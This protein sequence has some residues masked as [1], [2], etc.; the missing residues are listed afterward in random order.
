[1]VVPDPS[2][3][4]E[5]RIPEIAEAKVVVLVWLKFRE[6]LFPLIETVADPIVPAESVPP[7][8]P[9]LIAPPE[10]PNPIPTLEACSDPPLATVIVP[11]P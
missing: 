7:K 5:P 10:P 2:W 3:R 9:I 4:S 1:M 11:F 8:E 6:L